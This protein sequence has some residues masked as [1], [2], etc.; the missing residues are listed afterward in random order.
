MNLR[1]FA[2]AIM[3]FGLAGGTCTTRAETPGQA[4]TSA[5]TS[6]AHDSSAGDKSSPPDLRTEPRMLRFSS[7]RIGSTSEPEEI[8]ITNTSQ[9]ELNISK[10]SVESDFVVEPIT[11]P[12][13][14][15]PGGVL[16]VQVRYSPRKEEDVKD[17]LAI[18]SDSNH[19][20]E[21]VCL[22]GGTLDPFE[23]ICS[24]SAER[25]L[26]F[27]LLF[28]FLYWLLM[29][30]VRW[31]KIAR[32]TR[33]L[34]KAQI[35]SLENQL[36]LLDPSAGGTGPAQIKTMLQKA[37]ALVTESPREWSKWVANVLFWS[38]GH[39]LTGWGYVHD[40]EIQMAQF[41]ADETV[42]ARL[43]TAERMLRVSNDPSSLT[44]ANTI[45]LALTNNP[46]APLPRR[47]ALLAEALTINY[48]REDAGF[49][50]LVSWQNKASW[51][52]V[53]ALLVVVAL[54]LSLQRH[55]VLFL[56]GAVGG[57]LSR[58]SRSLDRKDVPTDYGASWSTLFLS[59][60][61][62][63]LGAWAGILIANLAISLNVLGNAFQPDWDHPCQA[64][65]LAIALVFG[66]SERLLDGVLDK[67]VDKSGTNA[68]TNPQPPQK[69]STAGPPA[70]PSVPTN[71]QPWAAT[72]LVIT[73]DSKLDDGKV[74]ANYTAQLGATGALVGSTWSLKSGTLPLGLQLNPNG[75]ISGQPTN[76]GTFTFVAALT[77][78]NVSQEKTFVVTINPT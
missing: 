50:D 40:A 27:V 19:S 47:R 44:M 46:T 70:P 24:L 12:Q 15:K 23:K 49:A 33:E 17:M 48:E 67:L 61:S 78:A 69:A 73:T 77:N 25:E 54:T 74:G 37:T 42:T 58:M 36:T 10:I 1:T 30:C 18:V 31:H 63:A 39:E 57:L 4:Q 26:S 56:V 75:A 65:T 5:P 60:A 11:F 2:S 51:L 3:A 72:T 35:A 66:F 41:L 8:K 53:C 34:L 28:C 52:V 32:P 14:L 59:P 13:K 38:R 43:E 16:T 9:R 64:M 76:T 71:T 62:G 22:S 20:P 6:A 29:I 55:A 7:Q 45:H 21:E 68:G